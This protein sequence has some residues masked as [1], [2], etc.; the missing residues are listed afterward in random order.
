MKGA[1]SDRANSGE[2][3]KNER[4]IE[5]DGVSYGTSSSLDE[6]VSDPKGTQSTTNGSVLHFGISRA[7]QDWARTKGD[8][9][10]CK[11]PCFRVL[12]RA[13]GAQVYG[14]YGERKHDVV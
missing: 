14:V 11:K 10:R 8:K 5:V 13:S 7:S 2:C 3:R 12:G 4:I 1:V 6:Y 9:G